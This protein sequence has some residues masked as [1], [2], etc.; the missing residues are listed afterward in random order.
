MLDW[1]TQPSTQYHICEGFDA[2]NKIN[3][4]LLEHL[5]QT[6]DGLYQLTGYLHLTIANI[7]NQI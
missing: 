3:G 7:D 2:L 4:I 1:F 6:P 5:D